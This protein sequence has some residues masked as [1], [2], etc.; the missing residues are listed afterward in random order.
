MAS[1]EQLFQILDLE[2]E[3]DPSKS[4]TNRSKHSVS[5]EEAATVYVDQLAEVIE[6][7]LHSEDED[8]E[9]IIGM[10]NMDRLLIVAYTYRNDRI[11]IISA[12]EPTNRERRQYEEGT[13][14]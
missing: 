3:W 9:I 12:R 4:N 2:F 14:S 7:P 5:F 10:S 1:S 13:R 6:D 11:R 8:R